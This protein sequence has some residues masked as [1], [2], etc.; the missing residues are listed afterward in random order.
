MSGAV[1][2]S[3]DT[4]LMRQYLD[5]KAR[6]PGC[7]LFFRLGDFYEMFFEDAV[8]VARELDL[9]LTSRD[10]GKEKPIPMCGVPHH[11]A[12][13]Y[14][15]KLVE[16]GFKVAICEQVED[17]RLARGIVRREVVRI[18]TPGTIVDENALDPLRSS[19]LVALL[20]ERGRVG[21]AYLEL[22]TGDFAA[23]ELSPAAVLDEL[24]RLEPREILVAGTELESLESRLRVSVTALVEPLEVLVDRERALGLLEPVL[25]PDGVGG[26]H[27]ARALSTLALCAAAEAVRYARETQP[28]GRIPV[29]RLAAYR[30][31]DHLVLDEA[32]RRNLEIARTLNGDR[33][34][35]L[36]Q[37]LDETRTAMGG[38]L[39][40]RWL[41]APL[42]DLA[43]I[44]RR[45]DAVAWLVERA[46]LRETLRVCFGEVYDLE[47]L[48]GRASLGLATPRD[49]VALKLSLEQLPHLAAELARASGGLD[50][51]AL[52]ALPADRCE[53]VCAD[54]ARTLVDDPP[55]NWREGGI[56]RRGLYPE[57]D[58]LIDLRDGGQTE[59]ERIERDER[60]RSG[61]GSLKVRY[62]RVFGYYIEVTRAHLA[63]VPADFIR[64][65]TLANAERYTT[66]ALQILERKLLTAEERRLRLELEAFEQ[67]RRRVAEAS[68]R[69]CT[70]AADV[71]RLDVLCALAEVAHLHGYCRPEVDES[72]VLELEAARHPVVERLA[73]EG[74]FVPNDLVLDAEGTAGPQLAILTGPNMAGK[75]TAMRQ[76]ALIVLLAQAGSFVPA[77][78]ARIG[79]CD[80]L[81]T[82]VGAS[83]NLARGESTF[84]VE[85]RETATILREATRRSFVILDEIGRG[86]ST[87]DGI[88]IAWAVAE[89]LH[90]T[91]GCRAIFATHYHELVA[92]GGTLP[93]AKNLSTAVREQD[94][95]IVF[96]HKIV[97]GGASRSYGIDVARLAGI[98]ESVILRARRLLA[99]LEA[100]DEAED[101]RRG[102]AGRQLSLLALM[103][104]AAP[105]DAARPKPAPAIP[106]ALERT[107]F[108]TDLDAL[109]PREAQALLY[110]LKSKLRPA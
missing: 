34:G 27:E 11:A 63:K 14:L 67:L 108:D 103:E 19:Y 7:V 86:T 22:S 69:L 81:F 58:E 35:S 8:T 41:G 75:S 85:M 72:G 89:A 15:Q 36:T 50:S 102:R 79:L 106:S 26:L 17:P 73:A 110:E 77:R 39:L 45:Q 93:R 80:R 28:I 87:F 91:I 1:P 97:E 99:G 25:A 78:R 51:P 65:Q 29:H 21:L 57:L 83:D 13:Q 52:V 104:E 98:D 94:G 48:A 61:I 33:H 47:R 71:A 40:R 37:I 10:K 60:E 109:S 5:V 44:R 90:D 82:R 95:E 38:R 88:S 100:S 23:T 31:A 6:H 2:D 70:L 24:S 49:L 54:I 107:L 74:R 92:L 20:F 46:G 76:A 64:R 43:Q 68:L 56:A 32:T 59:I 105:P 3:S 16:R 62:N 66:E 30:A 84:M 4:P 101:G 18:V 42:L 96:L 53:D 55:A 9:T 12:A